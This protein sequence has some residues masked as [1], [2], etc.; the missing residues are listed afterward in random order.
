MHDSTLG[1]SHQTELYKRV[2][3]TT[4][5]EVNNVNVNNGSSNMAVPHVTEL[6]M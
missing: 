1:D 6:V 4:E 3:G 5:I 2:F